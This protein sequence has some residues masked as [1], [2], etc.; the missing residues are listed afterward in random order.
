MPPVMMICATPS[1]FGR[2][3]SWMSKGISRD[4]EF[5]GLDD[6][7]EHLLAWAEDRA[8]GTLRIRRVDKRLAKIERVVVLKS[9]RGRHIGIKLM[10]AALRQARKSGLRT[11][12]L[13]AQTHAE[14]FYEKLGF[15]AHGD[16]FDEDGIPHVAMLHDLV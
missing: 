9:E 11:V 15:V 4:V 1:G 16:I 10:E 8:V 7:C 13:H 3:S 6:Q 14:A 12:R 5:D 2:L